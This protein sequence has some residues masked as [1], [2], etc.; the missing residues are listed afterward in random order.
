MKTMIGL[1]FTF[2]IFL[3]LSGECVVEL[4]DKFTSHYVRFS[5]ILTHHGHKTGYLR[6]VSADAVSNVRDFEDVQSFHLTHYYLKNKFSI[7]YP[8]SQ[9]SLCSYTW[10]LA[11]RVCR[12]LLKSWGDGRGVRRD[13]GASRIIFLKMPRIKVIGIAHWKHKVW[14]SFWAKQ[15]IISKF[16]TKV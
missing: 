9:S 5:T 2:Y 3:Y 10:I 16:V 4:K 8:F 13:N 14:W 7:W 12:E 11:L 6:F 15:S 1:S